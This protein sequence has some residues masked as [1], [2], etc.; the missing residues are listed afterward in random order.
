MNKFYSSF[1]KM[2]LYNL[3]ISNYL[4]FVWLNNIQPY[5]HILL[6]C[7]SV[8]HLVCFHILPVMNSAA[9][10]PT[11]ILKR[12]TLNLYINLWNGVILT[13]LFSN[14]WTWPICPFVWVFSSDNVF[15]FSEKSMVLFI[16]NLFLN[17]LF[18]MLL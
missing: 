6:I 11:T 8:E 15:Q 12:I 1:F 2:F 9:M 14:W 10:K 5:T 3:T 4:H 13:I 7:R 17:I 18:F 16:L